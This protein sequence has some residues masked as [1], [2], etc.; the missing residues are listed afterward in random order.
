MVIDVSFFV[1]HMSNHFK[2]KYTTLF[3]KYTSKYWEN[4]EA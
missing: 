3:R 1:R 2:G 4:R